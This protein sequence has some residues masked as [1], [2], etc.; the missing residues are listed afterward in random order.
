MGSITFCLLHQ[1]SPDEYDPPLIA[2]LRA[3]PFPLPAPEV[4]SATLPDAPLVLPDAP[5][6]TPPFIAIP[7]FPPLA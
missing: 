3:C 1:Y 2:T 4:P 7:P 6:A 5:L